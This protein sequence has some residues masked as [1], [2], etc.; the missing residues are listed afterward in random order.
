VASV[1][2]WQLRPRRSRGTPEAAAGIARLLDDVEQLRLTLSADLSAAAGALDDD[3]VQ[4]ARDIVAA[5]ALEVRRLRD[6]AATA[7]AAP[8]PAP[9]GSSRRRALLALPA[10]P[11]AGA[12]AMTGAAA[13]SGHGAATPQ[14]PHAAAAE[15]DMTTQTSPQEIRQTAASTLHRLEHVVHTHRGGAQVVALAA[16]LHDQISAIIAGAPHS[17]KSL[18]AVQH[19]LLVEQRLLEHHPGQAASIALAES[20]RLTRLLH[21][22]ASPSGTPT[23]TAV[24][25]PAPTKSAKPSTSPTHSH[26]PKPSSPPTSPPATPSGPLPSTRPTHSASPHHHKH[27]RHRLRNQLIGSGLL[28]DSV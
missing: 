9:T 16:H 2:R 24:V 12:L 27:H 13:F 1:R 3:E 22:V 18:G 21:I 20:R 23:P 26:A 28:Q 5:D 8:Q 7:H 19:L 15:G 17:G 10:I 11:L 6:H 14:R 4:V 25:L